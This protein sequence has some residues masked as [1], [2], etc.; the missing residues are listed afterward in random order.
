MKFRREI[1]LTIAALLSL[2]A[3]L[4]ANAI[5][6]DEMDHARA[7]TAQWYLRWANN[8]SDYLDNLN[9]SSLADLEGNLKAKEKDNIKSFKNVPMPSDYASW[10]KE[11][12]VEYWSSTFFKASGLIDQ[13][14]GARARVKKKLLAMNFTDPADAPKE[15]PQE[16]PQPAQSAEETPAQPAEQPE[17]SPQQEAAPQVPSAEQIMTEATQVDSTLLAEDNVEDD[18]DAE[19]S[20]QSIPSNWFYIIALIVLVGI[21]V[22][23]VI[24]ASRTMQNSTKASRDIPDD[25][26]DVATIKANTQRQKEARKRREEY[27]DEEDEELS[28]GYGPGAEKDETTLRE[29]FARTLAVR[30]EDIRGLQ[31]R[32][33]ESRHEVMRLEEH[34]RQLAAEL[35]Q[36]RREL[37]ALRTGN[38]QHTEILPSSSRQRPD[39][40][41]PYSSG[42]EEEAYRQPA[43]RKLPGAKE[44]YLGRVNAQGLFVRADRRP[45]VGKSVFKLTTT[46]SYTGT[47]QV[48]QAAATIDM[49]LADPARYLEGGCVAFDILNTTEA[50]GIRTLASGTAIFEEGCWKVL[51]KAK[52]AYE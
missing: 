15:A 6:R 2:G 44:I 52:I 51:R 33:T 50:D 1:L 11:K 25:D 4:P 5:T 23:L 29:K 46:D 40:V 10:D 38:L 12:A 42:N 32:L 36:A 21:V 30:D 37:E 47:Y 45:V 48:L 19:E 18:A 9:P 22:W 17:A 7:V 16:T 39:V 14:R 26:D 34:N 13:G 3:F 49:A 28:A 41:S 27:P 35:S 43:P 24:F 8:G 20:K 31:R